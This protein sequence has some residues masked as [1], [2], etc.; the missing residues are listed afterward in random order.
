MRIGRRTFWTAACAV[1]LLAI[2]GP[3][4][5]A[6]V[7]VGSSGWEWG[8]PLPQGNTIRAMSFAGAQGY[9]AGDFGTLLRTDDAGASWTGLLA[10]TYTGLSEAQAIDADSLFAAGGCVA[11]RS[12]DGGR[13]FTRVAF[14][15]VESS[16]SEQLAAGWFV[17]E[18]TGYLVLTDG[19]VLRTDTNGDTFA[20][21]TALPGTRAQGGGARP[22]D[23]VFTT[24]TTGVAATADGRL[25][26]TTD[27]G[28][29]W[30]LVSATERAVRAVVFL[31]ATI[32][33]AVGDGSLLLRTSDGG[34]TWVARGLAGS[35][36]AL[37]SIRCASPTLCVM[38]TEG[39][40]QLVRT[41][42][43]GESAT[44]VTPSPDPIHAA[45]FASPTRIV[46]GGELGST[47]LS[48]DAGM[49]FTAVGGRLSGTFSRMVAGLERGTAFAPG[50]NGT[51]ARTIDG[52]R[53]WTR[54]NV[55]TSEDVLD[56]AFPTPTSGY[57]LDSAGGLFRTTDAGATWRT[58][59]TGTTARPAAVDAPSST[60]V[61]LA[62]PRG[63]RR[64]T[65]AGTT[66]DAVPGRLVATA[67]LR[68]LDRA[69]SASVA[70]GPAAILRSVD[71]GRTWLRVPRP[72][73]GRRSS[74]KLVADVDFVD[75]RT[76]FVLAADGALYRTDN[77]GRNY[78]ALPGVGTH[79]ALG[80]SFSSARSGYLVIERFGDVTRRS[81]F[82]LRTRDGGATWYPQF[83]VSTPIAG[84]GVAAA[85]GGTDYLLGGPSS[86][87]A[88]TTGGD[89][90]TRSALTATTA[91]RSLR[92]PARITVTGR[93]TPAAGNERVTVSHRAGGRGRIARWRAQTVKVAANGAYT[94]SWD[95]RPGTSSFVAQWAGDF[96]SAGD[97]SPVLSV[98]VG[99]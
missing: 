37:T 1:T 63:V 88:S 82:L 16:C 98:R 56:V 87:L 28:T 85:A 29:S 4:A 84:A 44:L 38:T 60:V 69:G 96:R 32:G 42:D 86:L 62:G 61:L 67:R 9:A 77:A 46:A 45:A 83:V 80:M 59:D 99:G 19:T 24:A 23:I 20:Q 78:T 49:N 27:G 75:A 95:V 73:A 66:F 68:G 13:T 94:T 93:L 47:A 22:N 6:G 81:G 43:G 8:N 55:S 58:L 18:R 54:G 48:D 90:G 35:G 15:P 89:A 2:G 25:Y 65:D 3:P 40:G 70:Y 39:G 14:T 41:T 53:T 21:V 50:A 64:S 92:R 57:A 31:D 5:S 52:G 91:R 51:L 12:D 7:Q 74:G 10:G 30:A 26:R 17:D 76:G 34:A 72:G 97:G 11:R 33:Y 71:R 79:T 36:G